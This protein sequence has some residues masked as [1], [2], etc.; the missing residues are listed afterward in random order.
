[1]LLY[2]EMEVMRVG[3]TKIR[4][5]FDTIRFVYKVYFSESFKNQKKK[6]KKNQKRNLKDI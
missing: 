1:M 3:L 4:D 5:A 6:S 2:T